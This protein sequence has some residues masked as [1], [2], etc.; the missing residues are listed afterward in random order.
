MFEK[1]LA[2]KLYM[3]KSHDL[4]SIR[5][6]PRVINKKVA[7]ISTKF[8][9]ETCKGKKPTENEVITHIQMIHKHEE[10]KL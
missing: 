7:I 8:V 6:T 10:K 5:Y 4:K 9:C 3:S 1:D 2:M